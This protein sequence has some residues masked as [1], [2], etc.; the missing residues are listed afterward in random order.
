MDQFRN[1]EMSMSEK[2]DSKYTF[3]SEG[4]MKSWISKLSLIAVVAVSL[5]AC[6]EERVV[7]KVKKDGSGIV[8]HYSYNNVEDAMGGFLSGL[9]EQEGLEGAEET[10]DAKVKGEFDDAYFQ[11]FASDMGEGVAVQDYTLGNNNAGMKGYHAIYTFED[12]N[13][14]AVK[15]RENMGGEGQGE[16][17]SGQKDAFTQQPD[18]SMKDGVLKIKIPHQ[19]DPNASNEGAGSED[20]SDMP[21]QMMGMM[22]AMLK[23]MRIAVSVEGIDAIKETNALHRNDNTIVI[24]DVQMDKLASDLDALQKMSNVESLSREQMQALA[25]STDGMDIDLQEEIVIRF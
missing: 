24:T 8:E 9:M 10:I 1:N 7:I 14:I 23:G 6:I 4:F 5:S 12:I 20:M 16:D 15:M 13:N 18:F 11:K 25:D 19:Y 22:A 2:Q 17:L 21:P 3:L